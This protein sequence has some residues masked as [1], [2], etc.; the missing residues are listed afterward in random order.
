MRT[1]YII[2]FIV[3]T[4]V[5]S[6]HSTAQL[7]VD[8]EAP[9]S[10]AEMNQLC[11]N[12][13]GQKVYSFEN[14]F[15]GMTERKV[16][17]PNFVFDSAAFYSGVHRHFACTD[18]HSPDY[19][20]FPHASELRMEEIYQCID[21]HGGDPT[22]AQ[23]NFEAIE[24]EF[25]KSVHSTKHNESFKCWMCHDP[26]SYRTMTHEN[27]SI[28]DIVEYHNQTCMSCHDNNSVKFQ[29]ISD[30]LKPALKVIHGF[31]PNFELHFSAV[32]CIECHTGSKDTMWVAH[33]ILP[34]ENAVKNCVDC[35]SNSTM[36]ISK[37]Y[38]YQNIKARKN[39]GT[40]NAVLLNEAYVIGANRN[41]YL[42]IISV[43]LFGVSLIGVAV[44]V[45]FRIKKK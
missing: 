30:T 16:M 1:L 5:W 15:S 45:Y 26:H 8:M 12:C 44:H 42:N 31:L 11:F 38:K 41:I 13:H 34:K 6:N 28:S 37:L 19:E 36:L 29:R 10:N 14:D 7:M 4:I 3:L 43:I 24:E 21:C 17:N 40:F 35:H 2:P 32:R 25:H 9:P 39:R 22:Y 18:C 27:N 33:N 20:N 23:Y